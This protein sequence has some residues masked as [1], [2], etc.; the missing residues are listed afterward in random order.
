[1]SAQGISPRV[2]RQGWRCHPLVA[3]TAILHEGGIS[4]QASGCLWA[5]TVVSPR[6]GMVIST[7]SVNA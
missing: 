4:V 2:G 6:K 7:K 5:I 3:A 1:M